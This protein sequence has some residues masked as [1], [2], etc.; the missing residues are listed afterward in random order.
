MRS[1]PGQTLPPD[2]GRL[3]WRPGV[4]REPLRIVGVRAVVHLPH[5]PDAS[6]AQMVERGHLQAVISHGAPP[7]PIL[8]RIMLGE[9]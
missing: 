8:R 4:R 6:D 9:A 3:R 5:H 1:A 2:G 7:I